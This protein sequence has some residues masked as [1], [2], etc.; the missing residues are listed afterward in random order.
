MPAVETVSVLITDLVGSTGLA[1]RLGPVAADEFRRE[2][3]GVLRKAI[4]AFSGQE[5]K[6]IGDGLMVVFQ[7][8]ADAVACAVSIQ[9]AME[10]R[11]RGADE[12][13]A[14]REGIALGD[15]TCEEGD[16]FGMPVVE[17]AR[18]CD[19]AVGGQ[20][21]T[22][23]VV[24]MIDVR[25]EHAFSAVGPLKLR[26]FSEPVSI[27]EVGWEPA[28][29][30]NGEV[31]LPP[32]LRGVP[33]VGYVGRVEERER[34]RACW[35]AAG[36]GFRHA[37][38]VSGEPG[39]G[40][41]RFTTHAALEFHGEAAVVLFGHCEQE[42]GTP[43]GAW[44]QL[45]SHLVENAPDEAL[46]AYVER[47][48]GELARLVPALTR[49]VPEAPPPR[50]T[51]PETERYLLFSAVVGLLDQAGTESPV[52]LVLDDLHWADHPTLALLRFVV[53]ETHGVRLLILGT[54]RDSDLT[55]DHP[56]TEML[57]DLRR[58]DGIERLGLRGL[59]EDEVVS[60][61]EAAAGH[62]MDAR[63]RGL[64]R[65]IAAETGGNPFF[66]GEMLRHLSE[67]GALVHATDG[68]W[69]LLRKLDELGLPQSVREVVGRRVE[70]LGEDCRTVLSC[71]AVIGRDFD[72]ELLLR[73]LRVDED[74]LID[75]LDAAVEASLLQERPDRTGAFSFAH[76]LINHTLYEDLG[77]TRRARLH[78]RVAEALEDLCAGNPGARVGELARHWTAATTPVDTGKALDYSR[79]AGEYALAKLAP[80]EA[81]RWF[82]QG[83]E[84]LE[85]G[86]DSDPAERCE[87][88]IGLGDAQRQA[89]KPEFRETLLRAA[90]IAEELGDADRMARAALANNRGFASVFG[91]VDQERVAALERAIQLDRRSNPARCAELL[92]LQSMELQFDPDHERRRELAD[93]ALALAR[94]AGD[95]RILPYVLRDHFHATWSAYTLQARRDTV[96]EMLDLADRIDDPLARIWALD[97]QIHVAA[98]SGELGQAEEASAL[99]LAL[100][101]ELGQ[102]RLRWHA[103]YYAAG[104]A[105]MA[106]DLEEADRLA[107]ASARLGEQAGEPDTLMIYFGQICTIRVEQGRA[108]EV[109]GMIEQ[110]TQANPGIPAFQAGL[111]AALCDLGREAEAASR[112]EEAAG[113][114]FADIPLNQVY[115]TS[116]AMWARTAAEVGSERAAALLYDVMEPWRG[117]L[118]WNGSTGYGAAESYLGM[119][120]ATLGSHDRASEHF[121][122]ASR[123]HQREGVK[124]WEA[125][126]LYYWARSLVSSGAAEE[127]RATALEALALARDNGYESRVRQAE[128]IL[129][130]VRTT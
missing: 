57:A 40:K 49:R 118:V 106:G 94:E 27:Y 121:A 78:R 90:G 85:K 18:L 42:L 55:R 67:S 81:V 75:L 25:D 105:E 116:F 39:I 45:L 128:S 83:L 103:T 38:L 69:Q 119:L 46:S 84:L 5:V 100:T 86:A 88:T 37:L 60:L 98:E 22:T 117:G 122:A 43:Y 9:Q 3:F 68:R 74:E 62:D 52:V 11:N 35:E 96:T 6:N 108:R 115:S 107:E 51:D 79:R 99:L 92:A 120:A 89:G 112:L 82:S 111:A 44:I 2:H 23:E 20:I 127:A 56:L 8:A 61:M 34:V 32:R 93:E 110:A 66:V 41:T 65:E 124:G 125:Q 104:L 109:V 12:Q 64:A 113:R 28:G 101:E 73:I 1:S 71:A 16:Y 63:G 10:Q 36:Q 72:I 123:L 14:I 4:G 95:V 114:R 76:N 126:N 54:Y 77:A 102:P 70:R 47:H 31:P 15:V 97:R 13:L 17:A 7:G 48:G 24:R 91:A 33:P 80:D 26:G 50:Q 30:W 29:G 53:A 21:L 19:M 59:S 129:E 58:E 87:L 130:L